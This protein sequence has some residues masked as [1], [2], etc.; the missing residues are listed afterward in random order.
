MTPQAM[1]LPEAPLGSVFSSSA[2]SW[3]T[4]EVPPLRKSEF[5]AAGSSEM[6]VRTKVALPLWSS[7]TETL[8]GRSPLWWPMSFM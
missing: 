1:R 6:E 2:F 5:G 7:P 8:E 4:I 3:T